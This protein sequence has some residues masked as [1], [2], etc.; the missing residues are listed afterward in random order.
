MMCKDRKL[1]AYYHNKLIILTK[2][3][4]LVNVHVFSGQFKRV[5]G[6]FQ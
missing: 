3:T 2:I 6:I 1:I 5:L 4:N